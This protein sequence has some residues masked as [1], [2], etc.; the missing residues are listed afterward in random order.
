M[1]GGKLGQTLIGVLT[2]LIGRFHGGPAQVGVLVV[3]AVR[4]RVGL[5][6]GR[7]L[8]ASARC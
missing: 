3:D 8:G 6:G 4:R 5:G 7:R 2:T 1:M